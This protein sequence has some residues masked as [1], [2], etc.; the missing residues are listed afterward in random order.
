MGAVYEVI[1]E[2]TAGGRALK[3]MLPNLLEN[4]GLRARFALE[5]RI[6]GGIESDHIV[7]TFDAGVDEDSSIPFLVM[8]LLRGEDLAPCSSGASTCRRPRWPS[9]CS[10][11]RARSTRRTRPASSTVT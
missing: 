5:A 6:T 9:T 4:E 2:K 3:V 8:E 1:D 10:R 11:P 7:R